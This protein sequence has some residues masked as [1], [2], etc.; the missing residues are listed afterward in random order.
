MELQDQRKAEKQALKDAREARTS[1]A[2]GSQLMPKSETEGTSLQMEVSYF[3]A[4]QRVSC[5]LYN[6]LAWLITNASPEVSEDGRVHV[7]PKQH[8]QVLN[9]A[10]DVC[11]AVAGIPTPKHIG[12]A[13]HILK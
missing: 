8:E 13:L 3:E 11:Q 10:Q 5:N 9:L 7:N 4:S 12:T 1:S 2:S 6:H